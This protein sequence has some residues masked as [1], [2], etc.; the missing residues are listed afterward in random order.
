MAKCEIRR[1]A[2]DFGIVWRESWVAEALYRRMMFRS[3]H[4]FW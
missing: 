4:G 2:L 3:F 1:A